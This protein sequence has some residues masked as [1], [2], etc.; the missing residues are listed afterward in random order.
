M[1]IRDR[2]HTLYPAARSNLDRLAGVI[3]LKDLFTH[4]GEEDF[5]VASILRPAKF[6]HEETQVYTAL[7]QL[8]S[9]QVGYGIVCDEF[10]V[11]Q[12][13]VTLHDI[14][15][16]LVGSIPEEREEPDIVHREDGSC[17]IDGQCPFYDFLVCYGLEDVYPNNLYNTLSGL[18]LDELGHIPQTGE[19]L[20]WSTFTFEIV[21]M[22]GARIDKILA[23]ETSEKTNQNP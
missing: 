21:D 5:D 6:F 23:C 9:E 17:L 16:A 13:I 10:G 18:I 15:E 2:P 3:Y 1:C 11:T 7:E 20:R 8:R 22:D 14:F 12:G 19:K 4:I